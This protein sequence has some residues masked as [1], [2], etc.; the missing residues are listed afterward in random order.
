MPHLKEAISAKDHT[1][2]AK[3]PQVQIVE[4][5]DF[6]CSHCGQAE[7]VVEKLL[8]D[9]GSAVSLTFRNFPLADVHPMAQ[10]AAE[11]AE[12]AALQ[13]KYWEMHDMIFANQEALSSQLLKKAAEKLQLDIERFLKDAQSENTRGKIAHDFETGAISGVNGTPTFFVN[14]ERFNGGATDLYELIAENSTRS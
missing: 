13:G 12:A 3:N 7:P 4:Y 1:R 8:H 14:G 6:Q 10:A 5:G 9:F 11:A 2:G